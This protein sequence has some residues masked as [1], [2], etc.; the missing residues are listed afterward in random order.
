M[1]DMD[2]LTILA[3]LRTEAPHL[4]VILMSGDMSGGGR[5]ERDDPSR[6]VTR[7]LPKPFVRSQLLEALAAALAASRRASERPARRSGAHE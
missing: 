1:A 6:G 4:P 5:I 2:G 3:Q 7:L